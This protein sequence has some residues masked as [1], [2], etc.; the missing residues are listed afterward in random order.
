MKRIIFALI[1][2]FVGTGVSARDY[3][4]D[5]RRAFAEG[6]YDDASQ[7]YRA[8]YVENAID[9]KR[10]RDLC[11][12]CK[13]LRD[14]GETFRD[15]GNNEMAKSCFV[16]LIKLNPD[17][18]VAATF[19]SDV[20]QEASHP[21]A[22]IVLSNIEKVYDIDD[23]ELLFYI[24]P[25]RQEMTYMEAVEFCQTLNAGGFTDWR[26]P[27][28]DE[29]MLYLR[30][31]PSEKGKLLWVGHEGVI[32]NDKQT[33]YYETHSNQ[34]FHPCIDGSKLVVHQCVIN[35]RNEV[36][37]GELRKHFFFPVHSSKK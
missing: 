3:V 36:S 17:D 11:N 1:L 30:D 34:R 2:L 9:T 28:M 37:A 13:K 8:A 12:Q 35:S 31:Y 24:N 21:V 22:P 5:A 16:E 20:E 7:L 10:E 27:S 15:M 23:N 4:A 33:D 18:S 25:T 14:A 29:L 19:L 6:R 32:V 26:L